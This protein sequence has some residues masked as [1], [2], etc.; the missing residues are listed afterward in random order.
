MNRMTW[1]DI[2]RLIAIFFVIFNH[3]TACHDLINQDSNIYNHYA[4]L[5]LFPVVKMAVPL[6]FMVSGAL[7]LKK[8]EDLITLFKKRVIRFIAVIILFQFLQYMFYVLFF[9]KGIEYI[10]LSSFVKNCLSGHSF[11]TERTSAAVLWF[12]YAYLAY[13]LLLPF[14]R[15]MVRNMKNE[16]FYYLISLQLL[17]T[18]IIPFFCAWSSPYSPTKFLLS[19]YMFLLNWIIICAITGYFVENRIDVQKLKYLH[20]WGGISVSLLLIVCAGASHLLRNNM[21]CLKML[22]F[23]DARAFLIIPSCVFLLIL[24]IWFTSHPLS[25]RASKIIGNASG[26]VFTVMLV[27]NILRKMFYKLWAPEGYSELWP[28]VWVT[29]L[30]WIFGIIL[31]VIAKKIPLIRKIL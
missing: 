19:D 1:Y 9:Y 5:L 22:A 14:L 6:F 23:P 21:P 3:T 26:G 31:G 7:L 15:C 8:Q 12:L 28:S 20:V 18:I 27:E 13:I 30:V 4:V 25:S 24:K 16:H 29:C 17:C 11:I 10:S 2:I